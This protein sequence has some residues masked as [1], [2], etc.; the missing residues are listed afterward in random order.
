MNDDDIPPDLPALDDALLDALS[1]EEEED[2]E[3]PAFEDLE[4]EI[5]AAGPPPPLVPPP[6]VIADAKPP[7]PRT[8]TRTGA[9]LATPVGHF[10]ILK[11]VAAGGMGEVFKA[12]KVGSNS[13]NKDV[14]LKRI[15]AS[16]RRDDVHRRN[17][18]TEARLAAHL[19]H[20]NI[21]QVFDLIELDS[22]Y[23]LVMEY[24]TGTSLRDLHQL[25]QEKGRLLSPPFVLFI[26][27]ELAEA[28]F[29]AH[30]VEVDGAPLSIVHRDVS[31]HNVMITDSGTVKLLDF[32]VA[33]SNLEGRD[34]TSTGIVKGKVSYMSPEQATDAPDIDGRSDQFALAVMLAELLTGRRIFDARGNETQ[35]L[36]KIATCDASLVA[37]GLSSV[38]PGLAAIVAR[39]LSKDPAARFGTC[40]DF[41]EALREYQ[42]TQGSRFGAPQVL[43]EVA[44]LRAL[45]AY[46]PNVTIGSAPAA[47]EKP[48]PAASPQPPSPSAPPPAPAL[49]KPPEAVPSS[50]RP[51]APAALPESVSVSLPAM[52]AAPPSVPTEPGPTTLHRRQRTQ[53]ALYE[54]PKAKRSGFLLPVISFAVLALLGIGAVS[55]L[56][57]SAPAQ[58]VVE[59]VKTPAQERAERELAEREITATGAATPA[60]LSDPA[61]PPVPRLEDALPQRPEQPSQGPAAAP[62][63]SAVA[64]RQRPRSQTPS[65]AP[66]GP[67]AAPGTAPTADPVPAPV[68]AQAPVAAAAPPLQLRSLS[69]RMSAGSSVV[70]ASATTADASGA[71]GV[72]RGAQLAARLDGVVDPSAPGGVPAILT[73]AYGKLPA[74]TR[75]VCETGSLNGSR[76]SLSCDSVTLDGRTYAFVGQ[77]HGLDGRPGLPV[78]VSGG[79]SNDTAG[80]AVGTGERIVRSISPGGVLGE[81]AGGATDAVAGKARTS[82]AARDVRASPVARG[83]V[84]TIWVSQAF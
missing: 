79:T 67:G 2:E 58:T 42:F 77:A 55:L 62:Q 43:E 47:R 4:E 48:R 14:A 65:A 8:S 35:T 75:V 18:V 50:P 41:A 64:S 16:F 34:H 39:A 38:A 11:H 30:T 57:R 78:S 71:L 31:P 70:P 53:E 76:V 22:S 54:P 49:A 29:Y 12:R 51:A 36:F 3:L 7:E 26:T 56:T 82:A 6:P 60:T 63:S 19:T 33:Y 9:I 68:Q 13:W 80:V 73:K 72:P 69:T 52:E 81:L 40:R 45:P 37:S 23:V 17:F 25:A 21:V 10:K 15:I 83:T 74:G 44:S 61:P 84:F 5:A 32:G 46:Q 1:S 59:T 28:L 66:A 24:L 20:P 27:A